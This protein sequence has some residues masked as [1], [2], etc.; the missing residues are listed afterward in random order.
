MGGKKRKLT[1]GEIPF[2]VDESH[3]GTQVRNDGYWTIQSVGRALKPHPVGTRK[4]VTY[5]EVGRCKLGFSNMLVVNN[6]W[7]CTGFYVSL[8]A[9]LMSLLW[10][11]LFELRG[12][13]ETPWLI[14]GILMKLGPMKRRGEAILGQKG[15]W[16]IFWSALDECN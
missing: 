12:Q 4:S 16:R 5:M 1:L 3:A 15:K 11:R 13:S 10:K 2:L 6:G 8:M 14:G 9:N 7:R